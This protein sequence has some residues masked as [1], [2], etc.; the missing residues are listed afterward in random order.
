MNRSA[1]FVTGTDTGV[2][3]TTAGR[4]LLAAATMRGLRTRCFKPAESGCA[5]AADGT[6]MPR[7]AES[8]W[9]ATDRM[10]TRESACLYRF[11]EPVAPGVA[12]M[13]L[14]TSIDLGAIARAFAALR[15]DGPDFLL[16][17]GAGGLLVP[18]GGGKN[19][20]DLAGLLGLPLLIVARPTLGTIN[21]TLLTIEAARGRGLSIEGVIFSCGSE[22]V[23]AGVIASN[24]AEIHG[25]SGVSVLGT[26]PNQPDLSVARLAAAIEAAPGLA[27]LLPSGARLV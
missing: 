2:G 12:A 10:Q 6:L 3:K 11:E 21:H 23:D 18:L 22:D 16:V 25:G 27:A 17:E 19:I 14:G 4:A 20:A 8:L 26:L 15:D 1:Y 9:E 13:R 7:D 5:R 24:A